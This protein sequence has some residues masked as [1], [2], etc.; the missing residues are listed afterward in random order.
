MD[1]FD[2][3][4]EAVVTAGKDVGQKAKEVSGVAKLKLDIK[5]KQDYLQ[6][7]YASL[8]ETYYQKHKDDTDSEES[9]QFYLIKEAIDEIDRMNEEVLKLQGASACPNCGATMPEGASFCSSCGAK[10]NNIYEEE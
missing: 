6:K 1:F 2:K 10:M 3:I 9:E 7:Q 4:G 5:S 8:G